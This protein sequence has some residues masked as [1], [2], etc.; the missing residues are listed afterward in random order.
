MKCNIIYL[1]APFIRHGEF[2]LQSC[3]NW[4]QLLMLIRLNGAYPTVR[5]KQTFGWK[6]YPIE[7][8]FN[9]LQA[10]CGITFV[11]HPFWRWIGR[12]VQ[13]NA[14]SK[15]NRF[16]SR[17]KL[18][19][20]STWLWVGCLPLTIKNREIKGS[21]DTFETICF[22]KRRNTKYLS[23]KSPTPRTQD[24]VDG[25][26]RCIWCRS[27]NRPPPRRSFSTLNI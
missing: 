17:R 6:S 13:T 12:Y 10:I 15:Y 11:L 8:Q 23:T 5:L 14:L 2:H 22:D 20:F 25:P 21:E 9:Y 16:V 7:Q 26:T 27:P 3:A 18:S 4:C 24:G 1:I 19:C